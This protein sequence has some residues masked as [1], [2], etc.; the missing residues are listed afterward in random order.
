[1]VLGEGRGV[2]QDLRCWLVRNTNIWVGGVP[3][4]QAEALRKDRGG[5]YSPPGTVP[6][7]ILYDP[8]WGSKLGT[9]TGYTKNGK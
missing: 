8:G 2:N 9:E 6:S 4:S 1:M 7:F 5:T 3:L